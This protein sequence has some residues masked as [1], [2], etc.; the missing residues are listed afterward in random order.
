MTIRSKHSVDP[1]RGIYGREDLPIGTVFT[2]RIEGKEE[3]EY[4]VEPE[5]AGCFNCDLINEC[6]GVHHRGHPDTQEFLPKCTHYNRS[7]HQN[8]IFV[9]HFKS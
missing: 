2:V 8:V 3:M 1:I 6:R 5:V 7:D 4:V 9:R